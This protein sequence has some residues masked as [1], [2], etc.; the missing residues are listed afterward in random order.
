MKK[1]SFL[2][3]VLATVMV[4]LMSVTFVACGGSD[5]DPDPSMLNVDKTSLSFDAEGSQQVFDITSNTNWSISGAA[6]W[7][8]LSTTSGTNNQSVIVTVDRNPDSMSRNCVLSIRTSDGV[9]SKAVTI[10]QSVNSNPIASTKWESVSSYSDGSRWIVSLSFTS[11]DATLLL[12]EEDGLTSQTTR[13]NYTYRYSS[14]LVVLTPK[15][16]GNAVLEGRVENNMKMTLV[17][18]SNGSEVAVLYKQ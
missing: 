12:T 3:N 18:T 1:T 17:N 13:L 5:D 6:S 9:A 2:S 16:T 8:H 4:G 7:C 10:S 14:G 11:T 15:E